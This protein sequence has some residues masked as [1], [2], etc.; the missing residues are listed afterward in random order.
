MKKLLLIVVSILVLSSCSPR[1]NIAE[2]QTTVPMEYEASETPTPT[3]DE[4]KYIEVAV[5]E[6]TA[7]E[8]MTK[9]CDSDC[10]FLSKDDADNVALYTSAQRGED[11]R[12]QYDDSAEYLLEVTSSTGKVYTLFD[13]RISNGSVY[14]DIVEFSQKPYIIVRN[15]STAGDYTEIFCAAEKSIFKTNELNLN[16]LKEQETNLIYTSVPLYR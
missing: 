6:N 3:P 7:S 4:F 14:F 9:I 16:T 10:F 15:I 2:R 1:N 11:G 8:G 5:T 13:N 12:L